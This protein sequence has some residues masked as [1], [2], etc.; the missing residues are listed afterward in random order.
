MPVKSDSHCLVFSSFW[1]ANF[2]FFFNDPSK[3]CLFEFCGLLPFIY[4]NDK[5]RG[6]C[7]TN[8]MHISN[9]YCDRTEKVIFLFLRMNSK[10]TVRVQSYVFN[11]FVCVGCF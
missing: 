5:P 3:A 6:M 10:S 1:N 2:F 11:L 7:N 9:V 4:P 8:E